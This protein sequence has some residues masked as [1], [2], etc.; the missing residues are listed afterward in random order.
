MNLEGARDRLVDGERA[1]NGRGWL[2][3]VFTYLVPLTAT[4]VP[5]LYFVGRVHHE[6]YWHAMQ[7]PPGVI[8]STFE[9]YVYSGFVVL[10]IG[11]VRLVSWLPLGPLGSWFI[12]VVGVVLIAA[13]LAATRIALRAWL[14]GLAVTVAGKVRKWRSKQR[15]W[16]LK[17]GGSLLWFIHW[18]NSAFLGFLLVVLAISGSIVFAAKSG[19]RQARIDLSAALKASKTAR[20]AEGRPV[21]Y[22]RGRPD[23][24]ASVALG[25]SGDWCAIVKN[26]RVAVI[27]AESIERFGP[28][29][30]GGGAVA[31]K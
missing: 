29:P 15:S 27:R 13:A 5:A 7:V 10:A 12:V 26:G 2:R 8:V 4:L 18:L 31:S 3:F 14:N 20:V 16:N 1:D 19:E 30:K 23:Q 25:C 24:E 6:A 22:L 21:A 17:L 11:L 28:A 9:D